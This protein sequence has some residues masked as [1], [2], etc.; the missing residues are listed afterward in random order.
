MTRLLIGSLCLGLA[1]VLADVLI[2]PWVVRSEVVASLLSPGGLTLGR[3]VFAVGYVGLH[4]FAVFLGPA[5]VVGASVGLLVD[6]G[7]RPA[8]A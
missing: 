1:L 7:V 5:L 6:R 4:V 8:A 3:A 2:A